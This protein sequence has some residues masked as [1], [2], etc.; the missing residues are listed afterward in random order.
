MT[1]SAVKRPT[2]DDV[3]VHHRAMYYGNPGKGKSTAIAAAAKLGK[4]VYLDADNGLKAAA[5]RRHG[6]PTKNI[7]PYPALSYAEMIDMHQELLLRLADGEPIFAVAWDTTTKSQEGFLD[8]VMPRSLAKTERKAMRTGADNERSDFEVYLEDRGE[9]VEM[10]KKLLRLYHGLGCHLLLGAHSRRDKD[11]DG[12]IQVNPALSPSVNASFA[13]WMD[14]IIYCQTES[15][16]NDPDLIEWEGEE[17]M[18]LTRPTGRF[19]AKDR[20][21][22]LPKRMINPGFDRVLGYLDGKI[23][24]GKDSLQLAAIARRRNI[25][26]VADPVV[27]EPDTDAPEEADA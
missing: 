18:G 7:E 11:E 23:V 12:A 22:V 24:K 17:F 14:W 15:F 8:E 27:D 5:L 21:G 13:G 6:I 9:V 1:L 26:K 3:Q 20:F 10:M 2:L 16:E 19:T 25:A 4:V